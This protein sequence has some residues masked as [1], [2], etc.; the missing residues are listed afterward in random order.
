MQS[1]FK[2]GKYSTASGSERVCV[3]E[4]GRVEDEGDAV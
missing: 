4:D 2:V 3:A 1:E